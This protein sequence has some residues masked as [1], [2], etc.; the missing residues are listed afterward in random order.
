MRG[1]SGVCVGVGLGVAVSVTVGVGV[2]VAVSTGDCVAVGVTLGEGSSVSVAV[3]IGVAVGVA[4]GRVWVAVASRV[5]V[6]DSSA[7]V[8]V[9]VAGTVAVGDPPRFPS[10]SPPQPVRTAST[11]PNDNSPRRFIPNP[12]SCRCIDYLL[13]SFEHQRAKEAR[14]RELGCRR[15]E[16][17]VITFLAGCACVLAFVRMAS[18]LPRMAAAWS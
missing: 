8:A 14:R 16:A 18:S 2:T 15:Q 4:G 7:S 10:S 17:D 13:R 3:G 9:A 12:S 1:G 5:G 11:I 6:G